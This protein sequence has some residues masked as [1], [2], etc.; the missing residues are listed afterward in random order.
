MARMRGSAQTANAPHP[1][2]NGPEALVSE[3][4]GVPPLCAP[5]S[6][7]FLEHAFPFR[8]LSVLAK[9]DRRSRDPVYAG[10][11]WWA[12]RPPSAM[13]GLL[14]AASLPHTASADAFWT[15]FTSSA[16]PLVGWRVHDSFVGGGTVLVEAARLG[17]TVSGTD[18]DPLAVEIVLQEL[19]SGDVETIRREAEEVLSHVRERTSHLFA[20]KAKDWEPL[21]YFFLRR[22]E[23]PACRVRSLLYRTPVIARDT[24]KIGAVVRDSELVAFCPECRSVHHM[25][26]DRKELRCCA[27]YPLGRGTYRHHRFHCPACGHASSHEDLQTAAAERVLIAVEETHSRELR[28]IRDAAPV[29]SESLD[30]AV[31]QL[32]KDRKQLHLPQGAFSELR[33]DSRPVSFGLS[34]YERMLSERQRLVFGHAFSRAADIADVRVRRVVQLGL[35]NALTTNNVLCG[36]AT[37]YGR[38]APLFSVRSYA[39]PSLSVELNPFHKDGGR[40]TLARLSEKLVRPFGAEVRRHTWNTAKNR[41]TATTTQFQHRRESANVRC[42]SALVLPAPKEPRCTLAVFDP[43][44]FDFISYSELSE[45]YRSWLRKPR[46]GGVPLL[47]SKED[48]AASFAEMFSRA[49]ASIVARLEEGRPAA[50]T[51]HATAEEAWVAI[52]KALD[53]AKVRVTAL[54]PLMNDSHMG[55]HSSAGNCEWDVVVVFRRASETSACPCPVTVSDWV[56]ALGTRVKMRR[57]DRRALRVALRALGPL[58]GRVAS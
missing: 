53:S 34:Q 24:G 26:A 43:P 7:T 15:M 11:R 38:L 29:D 10:H 36:Y 8:E 5:F 27:R 13:R 30:A 56:S 28:R 41:A 33:R 44:Y 23:C 20:R 35:S 1:V 2:E 9:A 25:S 57:P 39:L 3:A 48:P 16:H 14:V 40:G 52:A 55:H 37:D 18:T 22:V 51:F 45:F 32:R 31:T 46:L 4:P 49:V 19:L 50:F 47:P 58:Y 21:H 12:R 17:A 54:W 42:G 6:S